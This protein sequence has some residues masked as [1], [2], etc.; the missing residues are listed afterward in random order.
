MKLSSF[1]KINPADSVVVCLRPIKQGEAIEVDGKTITLLQDTP[2]GHKVL[3]N[4]AAEGQDIIKYGYPIGHAKKDLKQGEWVNENNLK[5]NLAGTLEYTYNPVEE[6][7]NIADEGRTFK[8]YVRKNGEVGTRNEVW[9]VPTVGCV[10]GVAEKLV[11][12]LKQETGCEGIDAIH[13]WHHNLVALSS[14]ATTRTPARCCA[15]SVSILT[16]VP[17]SFSHWDARTTSQTISWQCW[18]IT[19][20]TASSC[21]LPRRWKAMRL[22]KA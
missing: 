15:T 18:A 20:R 19:T 12:L 21:S 5:T 9:V 6:K 13:A 17:C 14:R 22:R 11:E 10:N 2:A 16:L 4:D 8:G 3:I 7:L 1:I